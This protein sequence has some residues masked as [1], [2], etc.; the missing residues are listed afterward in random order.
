MFEAISSVSM[1][2]MRIIIIKKTDTVIPLINFY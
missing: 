1:E 2:S